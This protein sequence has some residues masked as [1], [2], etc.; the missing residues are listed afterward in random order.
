M[1]A[2][3]MPHRWAMAAGSAAASLPVVIAGTGGVPLQV[4][5]AALP[6]ARR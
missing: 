4:P 6:H 5:P 1:L 3:S 2:I